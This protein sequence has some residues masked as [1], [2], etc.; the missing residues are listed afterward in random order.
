VKAISIEEKRW[1][2]RKE[3]KN[4]EDR[5]KI[6]FEYAPDAYYLSDLNGVILDGNKA[7][8]DL[9]RVTRDITERFIGDRCF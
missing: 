1:Q 6:L 5:L 7:A 9:I 8:E 2:A 3:L 4:S